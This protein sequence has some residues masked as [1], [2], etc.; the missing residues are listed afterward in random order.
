MLTAQQQNHLEEILS[1][2]QDR[3]I[4]K[5]VKGQQEHGGDLW[6]KPGMLENLEDEITDLIAYK[7]TL[8]IQLKQVL[9]LLEDNNPDEARERLT[10][11]LG[12]AWG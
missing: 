12:K 2:Q 8:R 5:Y 1:D 11:I 4:T 9:D 6:D 10:M 3:T 7:Y